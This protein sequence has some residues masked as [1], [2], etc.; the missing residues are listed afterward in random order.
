MN[1]ESGNA[2][3]VRHWSSHWWARKMFEW[4]KFSLNRRIEVSQ[5]YMVEVMKSSRWAEAARLHRD[6]ELVQTQADWMRGSVGRSDWMR[7]Q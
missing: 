7:R 4:E 5:V 6:A 2:Q 3:P 1:Y